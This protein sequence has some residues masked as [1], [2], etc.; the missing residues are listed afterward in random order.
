[1]LIQRTSTTIINKQRGTGETTSH[2]HVH[3]GIRSNTAKY[4]FCGSVLNLVE[5]L[6]QLLISIH[7]IITVVTPQMVICAS[8]GICSVH[9]DSM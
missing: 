5:S 4:L 1:M 3:D 9:L 8:I 6:L 7:L 2:V